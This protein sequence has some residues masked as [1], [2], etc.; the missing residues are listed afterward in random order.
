MLVHI[1]RQM[2]AVSV[3][4][5]GY[6]LKHGVA[7]LVEGILIYVY[8]PR[9]YAAMLQFEQLLHALLYQKEDIAFAMP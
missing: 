3:Y 9:R 1:G 2:L 4:G 5:A 8:A 6:I 7:L